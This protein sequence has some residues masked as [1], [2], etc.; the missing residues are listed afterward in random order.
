ML[1]VIEL[2]FKECIGLLVDDRALCWN[3]IVSSQ[4]NSPLES[5]KFQVSGFKFNKPVNI[6]SLRFHGSSSMLNLKLET[7]NLKLF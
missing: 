2:H 4:I 6:S 1:R 5:F 7:W 3:Q